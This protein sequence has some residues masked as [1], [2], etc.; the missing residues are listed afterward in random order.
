M[1]L[2][3][4]NYEN[5][6]IGREGREPSDETLRTLLCVQLSR[7]YLLI[8]GTQRCA[9]SYYATR[10]VKYKI[11][12]YSK[13]LNASTSLGKL[14]QN[15]CKHRQIRQ[16]SKTTVIIYPKTSHNVFQFP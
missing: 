4:L 14:T 12:K 10:A 13:Y 7:Y 15:I 9:L 16:Y 5:G 3:E 1:L 2:S 11:M 8:A 6:N